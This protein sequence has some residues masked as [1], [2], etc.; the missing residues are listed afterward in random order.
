MQNET[1][2][3]KR[4]ILA[5]TKLQQP[6]AQA[7]LDVR[8]AEP[9][10]SAHCY[11]LSSHLQRLLQQGT[12]SCKLICESLMHPLPPPRLSWC[13][14]WWRLLAFGGLLF[15]TIEK[16]QVLNCCG[17]MRM[18]LLPCTTYMQA[19]LLLLLLLLFSV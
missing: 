2:P 8:K 14:F 12:Q 4:F 3:T 11:C 1:F 15:S 16:G 18:T 5:V 19:L 10:Q 17:K 9:V 7:S 6:A 13:Q